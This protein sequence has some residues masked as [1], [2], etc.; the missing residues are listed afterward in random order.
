MNYARSS[1]GWE[2]ENTSSPAVPFTFAH[3]PCFSLMLV[4]APAGDGCGASPVTFLGR[5]CCH[6]SQLGCLQGL[7]LI[8]ASVQGRSSAGEGHVSAGGLPAT[9]ACSICVHEDVFD[10]YQQEPVENMSPSGQ[11]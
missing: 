1:N 8:S 7:M 5:G 6:H 10:M 3:S 4:P 11:R 2:V 9:P